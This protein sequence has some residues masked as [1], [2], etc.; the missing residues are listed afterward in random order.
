M[1]ALTGLSIGY[2][3]VASRIDSKKKVR[4]LTD[5]DLFEVSLVTF[6]ANEAARVSEVKSPV[7]RLVC[8]TCCALW[9]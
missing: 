2:R 6:L 7:P 3:V 9:V 1:G 4:M 8:G 5:V